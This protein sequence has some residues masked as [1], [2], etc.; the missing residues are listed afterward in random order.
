MAIKEESSLFLGFLADFKNPQSRQKT[1]LK[2]VGIGQPHLSKDDSSQVFVEFTASW[3]VASNGLAALLLD[4]LDM[5]GA[6]W[7]LF[8]FLSLLGA[9]GSFR[10][11]IELSTLAMQCAQCTWRSFIFSFSWSNE[12][13]QNYEACCSK[14]PVNVFHDA[15]AHLHMSRWLATPTSHTIGV[16]LATCLLQAPFR[17]LVLLIHHLYYLVDLLSCMKHRC[18]RQALTLRALT[19]AQVQFCCVG[20]VELFQNKTSETFILFG[21]DYQILSVHLDKGLCDNSKIINCFEGTACRQQMIVTN[22]TDLK[23]NTYYISY[24][25]YPNLTGPYSY[26]ESCQYFLGRLDFGTWALMKL[27]GVF[28]LPV[29]FIFQKP[30]LLSF[31]MVDRYSSSIWSS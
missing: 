3:Q 15:L 27:L 4:S 23:R 30:L 21:L 7:I 17:C 10:N 24:N 29:L 13:P 2:S 5:S 1:S 26:R 31:F 6:S 8:E 16:H 28:F 19:L 12:L 14:T 9:W 25:C 20:F 18:I 11:I 22:E